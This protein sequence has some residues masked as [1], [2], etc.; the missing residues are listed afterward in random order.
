MRRFLTLFMM[1]MF[2]GI[3]ASAQ[4]RTI[5]GQVKDLQGNP[6]GF[7]TITEKGTTNAVNGDAAGNFAIKVKSA[8]PTLVITAVG[9]DKQE[10]PASGNSVAVAMVRNAQEL[11]TV[12]VTSLG[13]VR[14]KASLGYSTA[15]VKAKDLTQATPVNITQGLN[16]KVSGLQINQ[17]NSG[18]RGTTRLTLRGI[19]SITGSNQPML[20]VDGI[21]IALD[22]L[23]SINPND[24][25][26]VSIL[27]SSSAT[28][29][30]GPEGVNGAVVI[31]T[32]R[33]TKKPVITFSQATQLEKIAYMPEFQ[34]EFGGGYNQNAQTGDGDWEPI[35]QQSWGPRFDGSIRQF[36]QTGP[37]GEKLIMPFA[38]NPKGRVNFF[39]TGVTNQTDVSYAAG[40]F[41]LSAQNVHISGTVPG[42][43]ET[44]RAVTFR[45]EKE[46]NKFKAILN[47]RYTNTKYDVTGNNTLIY[48][49]VTGAPGNYD[50]SRF[51]NWRT[52][53]FSSPDG[54]YTPYLDNNGKTPYFAKDT[55]REAGK[56]DDIF[57]NLELNYKLTN[58]LSFV[59][60]L[61]AN[62]TTQRVR[63]TQ[64]P[65][66]YSAYALTLRDHANLNITSSVSDAILY[67][68]S[69]GFDFGNRYTQEFFANFNTKYK[70]L[71]INGTIGWSQRDIKGQTSTVGASTLGFSEFLS[72]AVRQGDFAS[73]A[74]NYKTKLRRWFG[75]VGLDYKGTL[76][77][78]ATGSY[79]TDSRLSPVG[80][81][82]SVNDIS[83]F[84]PGVNASVLINKLIPSLD[85]NKIINYAKIR[86]AVTRTGN[87]SSV[88]AY[89]NA[90]VFGAGTFYPYNDLLG[91]QQ[92][93]TTYS[94]LKPEFVKNYEVGVELG[95][96][97]NRVNFEATYY[98]QDNT[99]QILNIAL[100]NTTGYNTLVANAGSFKNNGIELDLKLTPLVKI[101][102]MSV[103]FKINYTHQTNKITSLIDGTNE[104]GIGNFNYAIVGKPVYTFKLTDYERDPATGKVI[105]D[106]TTGL[107]T[108]ASDLHTFGNTLP[109]DILGLN[110]NIN[111]K[112]F[113]F[114][115]TGEYRTGNQIVADQL[116]SFLDDN[117]ISKRSAANGRRA[118]VFPNSVYETAPGSG[119][120]VDNTSIYTTLW[121]REFYNTDL[122]TNAASNYL[123]SGAFWKIRE[124]SLSYTVPSRIF[125]GNTIKGLTIGFTA[126]NLLTWLPK[127]NQWTDP[128]FSANGNSAYSGN[129]AGRSTAYN[130]PPTRIFGANA[131]F[132]F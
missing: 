127:S 17:T 13:Q 104:L 89:S 111:F 129:A 123:A 24:I 28:A 121:G 75:R 31:T 100:S 30:Y 32:K 117:G 46:Y 83:F 35:E 73:G 64:E 26:D 79:D 40:D 9:Y 59:Y 122:N 43:V 25:A 110:L 131:I 58:W 114:G 99:D 119:K 74:S 97:K 106:A 51:K 45:A 95:F 49:D 113:T 118:F 94:K 39:Q 76:F 120:Y 2:S 105:V 5:T 44:R 19:R 85:N 103:D 84:Y 50:L 7:A 126:R 37:N 22:Y 20:I 57:G 8:S 38:Y 124:I 125:K 15:S 61:G 4:S 23:N 80:S 81:N 72:V 33:G 102:Q 1:L 10:I 69:S 71:G 77:L 3:L 12:V 63:T 88:S 47:V 29:I 21:P 107:P 41:Y 54:Y 132:T 78:E 87:L 115:V 48:Y 42:D 91:F 60:R 112:G 53:Y 55:R 16:G 96:L 108:I 6:V 14:Q 86:G 52:D 70:N 67:G 62:V 130:M 82:Y 92:G 56:L 34:S 93:T 128:E 65:F 109:T 116:G 11:T 90:T 98:T 18:V 36:G 66:Q 68:R 27:K 101:G